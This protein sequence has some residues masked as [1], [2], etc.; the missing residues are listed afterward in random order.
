MLFMRPLVAAFGLVRAVKGLPALE[1]IEQKSSRRLAS[2]TGRTSWLLL[3]KIIP[4]IPHSQP[5]VRICRN[6]IPPALGLHIRP[7]ASASLQPSPLLPTI[8]FSC[9]DEDQPCH[10]RR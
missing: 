8:A 7:R 10:D 3:S 6:P 5:E 1:A 4:A 9:F 2:Q